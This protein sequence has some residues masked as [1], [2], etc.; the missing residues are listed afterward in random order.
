MQQMWL[1]GYQRPGAQ[2]WTPG[3]G[4]SPV[5]ART[6]K[7][8]ANTSKKVLIIFFIK[9]SPDFNYLS[10]E[11]LTGGR[12]RSLMGVR[13]RPNIAENAGVEHRVYCKLAFSGHCAKRVVI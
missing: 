13:D 4:I 11:F 8:R 6:T 10:S 3:M 1:S 9:F 5:V 12:E 7:V 2:P